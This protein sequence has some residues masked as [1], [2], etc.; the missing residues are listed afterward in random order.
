MEMT[1][2]SK[3]DCDSALDRL[4]LWIVCESCGLR[5]T[6]IGGVRLERTLFKASKGTEYP[7]VFNYGHGGYG[8]QNSWVCAE[9]AA[10]LLEVAQII[11]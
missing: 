10:D 5:P 4:R 11:L 2:T 1:D 3:D 8:Y 9:R 6:F 7:V